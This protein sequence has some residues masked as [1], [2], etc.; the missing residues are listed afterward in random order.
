LDHKVAIPH[1]AAGLPCQN[2]IVRLNPLQVDLIVRTARQVLG[3]AVQ[4]TL[5]GSRVQD[6]LRGGDVDLMM[7]VAQPVDTPAVLSARLASRLSRA[8]DGRKV[9][10]RLASDGQARSERSDAPVRRLPEWNRPDHQGAIHSAEAG[11]VNFNCRTACRRCGFLLV[12]RLPN[13]L[14][15]CLPECWLHR[16]EYAV[17][18]CCCLGRGLPASGPL[19]VL[20]DVPRRVCAS[21]FL[22]R[23]FA[24]L[25]LYWSFR[26]VAVLRND[27]DEVLV[28]VPVVYRADTVP[29]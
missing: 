3:P 22:G 26:C 12:R 21:M 7:E 6:H 14:R 25:E 15:C 18:P 2:L 20:L 8:M 10:R 4:V 28:N 29:R 16:S 1:S 11:P 24:D 17:P 13:R 27:R 9:E 19:W 5:F 23:R